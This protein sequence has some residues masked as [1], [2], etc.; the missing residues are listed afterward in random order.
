M[1]RLLSIALLLLV[2]SPV[3][4]ADKKK[5]TPDKKPVKVTYEDHV[6]PILMAR[7]FSCHGP[8]RKEGDLDLTTYG[9]LRVGGGSGEVVEPGASSDSYL[10]SLV[11]HESE[12]FMPPKSP[13]LPAKE[14]A[15]IKAWIDGGVLE[16]AG[17]KFV[18]KKPKFNLALEGPSTGRP[19]NP[20]FPDR[21]GLRPEL[22]TKVTTAVTALATS[23]WAPLCAVSGQKQ[24]LLYDTRSLE[25]VGVLAYPE[26]IAHTLGFSRN[27]SL[28]FAGGGRGAAN[29]KV[30]VWDVKSG[31]RVME[32]GEELDTVL[33]AD[34][35]SDHSM[36]ALGSSGKALRV[37]STKTGEMLWE[38]P[39]KH[40]NWIYCTSFSPDG[41]LVASSDRNGGLFVWEAE[42][43]RIYQDLRGHGGAVTGLSW[44]SDSNILA[45][46]G[47]D[48]TVRLWEM[49]NGR[50]VKRWGAHGGGSF[51]V[52]FCHD[53]NLVSI[54]RDKVAKLFKQDGGQIRAFPALPD[55]GLEVTY[56]D[57]TK[58]VIAGDYSGVVRVFNAADGKVIGELSSNPVT[59]EQRLV[60]ANQ[61]VVT[62]KAENDKQQAALKVAQDAVKKVKADLDTANKTI[63]TLQAKE[64]T[65]AASMK[66]YAGQIKTYTAEQAAAAKTVAALAKVVPLLKETADKAKATAAKAS[67]DKELAALATNLKAVYDKRNGVLLSAR[68][69]NEVKTKAL[70]KSKADL[71]TAQKEDKAA[72][73]GLVA[74]KKRAEALT[75]AMKPAGEKL[76]ATQ[77]VAATASEKFAAANKSVVR[78]KDEIEFVK[79][80]DVYGAKAS[81][82]NAA[83]DGLAQATGELGL[84]QKALDQKN[85]AAAE[86][87]KVYKAAVVEVTKATKGVADSQKAHVAATNSVAVLTK[88]IPLLK[89]AFDKATAA[90]KATGDK[91]L[92]AIATGLNGVH[93]KKVKA[94]EDGKKLVVTRKAEVDKAQAV[95]VAKQKAASASQTALT[96]AKKR[97]AD[98]VVA[99]KPAQAKVIQAKKANDAAK[100]QLD[101]VQKQVDVFKAK[102]AQAPVKAQP[103]TAK[104]G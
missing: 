76:A 86:A 26:G 15:T 102:T 14:L 43:G 94:L 1:T 84:L 78:W 88:A 41:V 18:R 29:G 60:T 42:T 30:V 100:A 59:L 7:C 92:A 24:V 93:G 65:L 5:P 80:L 75:K 40:T 82:F 70:T 9:K 73:A 53:G 74:T 61:L 56:C 103:A 49:E 22:V 89:D 34:I 19:K 69:T 55:L 68:K 98:Q 39:K 50:Q 101:A 25:L 44:R 45:S 36:I 3:S 54:G 16:N 63:S 31:K 8:N 81:E 83:A 32:V 13:K 37:F 48:G 57:E 85:T 77:K 28:L 79:V 33:G 71:A 62:T 67:G 2:A 66:T 12:P 47:Q 46:C 91:E 72:K 90:A 51:M 58:R 97:V 21:L 64:K 4:A 23:P 52:E 27:G 38:V 95:L 87:D 20:A 10:W 96:A 6:R 11:N 35:S 17:S 104:A 99:M